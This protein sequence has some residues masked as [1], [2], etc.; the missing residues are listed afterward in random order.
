MINAKHN[1]TISGVFVFFL[2]GVFAVSA[3]LMVLLGAQVYKS[4]ADR[5]EEHN[6]QRIAAAWM[7]RK[8]WEADSLDQI[9]PEELDG[10]H[11][12]KIVNPEEETVTLLYVRDGTLYEWYTLEELY[13]EAEF[14][15]E[16]L[17]APSESPGEEEAEEETRGEAVCALDEMSLSLSGQLLTVNLRN[18]DEWTNVD[19][20]LRSVP[21]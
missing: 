11:S 18:G 21:Q 9:R 1:H 14:D 15:G 17:P 5:A 4:G 3:T 7:R 8:L 2:L 20:V 13:G 10:A 19:I 6:A 12:V 16:S